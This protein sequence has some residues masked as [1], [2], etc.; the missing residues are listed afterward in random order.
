LEKLGV[1]ENEALLE[2]RVYWRHYCLCLNCSAITSKRKL[3]LPDFFRKYQGWRDEIVLWSVAIVAAVT[4]IYFN[5]GSCVFFS[6][7]VPTYIAIDLVLS[8]VGRRGARRSAER[9]EMSLRASGKVR[10]DGTCD[11]CGGRRLVDYLDFVLEHRQDNQGRGPAMRCPRC[12]QVG[13]Y[14]DYKY[15]AVA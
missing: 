10:D 2:G 8:A 3:R 15:F 14:H 13:L 12:G 5:W 11:Q 6:V 4:S 9:L 1:K 7:M